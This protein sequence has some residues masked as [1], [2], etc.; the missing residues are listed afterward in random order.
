MHLQEEVIVAEN[1]EN[2]W[3]TQGALLDPTVSGQIG[4]RGDAYKYE[5]SHS[6]GDILRYNRPEFRDVSSSLSDL[7]YDPIQGYQYNM[8]S[9]IMDTLY[10]V[11]D[12]SATGFD[13]SNF[14]DVD[15]LNQRLSQEAG[16]IQVT[17]WDEHAIIGSPGNYRY[18]DSGETID[19][20]GDIVGDPTFSFDEQIGGPSGALGFTNLFDKESIANTLS[21]MAG[22]SG[23]LDDEGNPIGDI[24]PG[25][26]T[27]LTPEMM[28]KTESKYYDPLLEQGREGSIYDLAQNLSQDV[29]GGFAG[30]GSTQA[31]KSKAERAYTK[32][33]QDILAAILKQKGASTEDVIGRI[34]DWQELIT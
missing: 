12:Q 22:Y 6:Q 34:Y 10:D 19:Q 2:P 20:Y 21:R 18:W 4:Y 8:G 14:I 28:E 33:I 16:P 1:F 32:D 7:G 26:V 31:H 3:M 5:G 13:I 15:S 11:F 23:A 30:S 25:E 17:D 24:R 27:A 9:S 29:S